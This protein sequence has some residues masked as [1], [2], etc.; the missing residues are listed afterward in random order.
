MVANNPVRMLFHTDSTTMFTSF[1]IRFLF[2]SY[3]FVPPYHFVASV[4]FA[5]LLPEPDPGFPGVHLS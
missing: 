3:G 1:E 5:P 4:L 2:Q